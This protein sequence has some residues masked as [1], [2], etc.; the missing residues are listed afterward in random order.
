M[1]IYLNNNALNSLLL[2][3]PEPP[4]DIQV[5]P[6][7]QDGTLLVT[8]QPATPTSSNSGVL[9]TGYAAVSYT[10][11]DV[12]KRQLLSVLLVYTS[13]GRMCLLH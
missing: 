9:V 11:L 3:L 1:K 10:H 6:G 8:W 2:G 7:P 4:V 12:Y 5:E 13:G